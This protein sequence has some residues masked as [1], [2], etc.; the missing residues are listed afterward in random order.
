MDAVNHIFEVDKADFGGKF[1]DEPLSGNLGQGPDDYGY[2]NHIY[3][4]NLNDTYQLIYDFREVFDE[5]LQEDGFTRVILTEAYADIKN[6]MRY[7]GD[8]VRQGSHLPFNF[9]LIEDVNEN[10]NAKDIK[11]FTDR[12]LTYM[13]VGKSANWVVSKLKYILYLVNLGHIHN[14]FYFKIGNH[15]KWRVGT[16]YGKERIDGL[17]MINLLLPGVGI[18]YNVNFI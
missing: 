7:Y 16:R 4:L 5:F 13:P 14:F 17:H 1:P 3:T 6:T 9:A 18:T 15:D 10:S 2:L 12:W 8:G 11:F